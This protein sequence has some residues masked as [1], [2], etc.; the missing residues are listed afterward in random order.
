MNSFVGV[1]SSIA[2]TDTSFIS[3]IN[4][5]KYFVAVAAIFSVLGGRELISEMS[6]ES[7]SFWKKPTVKKITLFF[8]FFLYARDVRIAL[9]I[10]I[11][12]ICA[13]PKVFFTEECAENY[14]TETM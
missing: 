5:H 8:I 4:T 11:S 7:A 2:G 12:V 14:I 3:V 10:C 6:K 1:S 9:I 13:F